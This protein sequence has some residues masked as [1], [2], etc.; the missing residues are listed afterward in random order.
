MLTC[1]WGW[2]SVIT[3][4]ISAL[5]NIADIRPRHALMLTLDTCL[6]AKYCHNSPLHWCNRWQSW[7]LLVTSLDS[8][9]LLCSHSL[10]QDHADHLLQ[11]VTSRADI[12]SQWKMSFSWNA[13]Y[14]NLA[15]SQVCGGCEW[16]LS[17]EDVKFL[18]RIWGGI[19]RL[20]SNYKSYH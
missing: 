1:D 18:P 13:F 16:W 14:S 7:T 11:L 12:L 5:T 4:V 8:A 2:N 3:C 15:A 17:L 20:I 9:S 6:S 19:I 10:L